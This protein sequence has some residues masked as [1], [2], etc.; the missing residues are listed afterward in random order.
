MDKETLYKK[1]LGNVNV[2]TEKVDT[3]KVDTEKEDTEK[4][5]K[6]RGKV[7]V[8]GPITGRERTEVLYAFN[9]VRCYLE[10]MGFEVVL[11]IENGLPADA[12]HERHMRC[13]FGLLMGC[14]YIYLMNGWSKSRGCM[15]EAFLSFAMGIKLL[16]N[17]ELQVV[18]G[19]KIIEVNIT[20]KVGSGMLPDVLGVNSV[21]FEEVHTEDEDEDDTED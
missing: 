1:T 10:I 9:D 16:H 19:N 20:L 15:S 8:S 17:E 4:V 7:Y 18:P 11:P 6:T 12:S 13:D 2:D 14:D 5:T 21:K 3:E